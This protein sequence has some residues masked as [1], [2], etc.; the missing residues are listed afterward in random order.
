VHGDR[1]KYLTALFALDPEAAT[2]WA[3]Q[4]G[5]ANLSMAALVNDP[6]LK[7]TI[8]EFVEGVNRQ[9]AQ[10]ETIKKFALLPEEFS[11]ENGYMT[12][13]MKLKRKAIEQ[14]F[15]QTLDRLY[16]E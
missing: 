8:N 13:T 11:V 14:D 16:A 5:K 15:A 10:Y 4:Q 3:E 1:R 12:P 6:E 9:V 2:V 7:S